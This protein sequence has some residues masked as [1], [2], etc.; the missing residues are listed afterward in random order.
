VLPKAIGL[1]P[2]KTSWVLRAVA[3]GLLRCAILAGFLVTLDTFAQPTPATI[4]DIG[5]QTIA[6]NSST[7]PIG[8]TI[9]DAESAAAALEL[10]A[11]SSNTALVPLS[12]IDF[13][14]I[15]NTRTVTVTPARTMTGEALIT[16][17]VTDGQLNASDSFLVRVT[18]PNTPPTISDIPDQK[19]DEDG[20]TEP[21]AFSIV[22][23]ETP[24][25]QLTLDVSSNNQQLV[26]SPGSASV[27]AQSARTVTVGRRQAI[28]LGADCHHRQRRKRLPR[29]IALRSQSVR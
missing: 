18:P 19:I 25:D 11:A 22:D 7:G 17:T 8:F 4:S 13:G 15:R 26:P 10:R 16:I 21:V 6:V 23:K 1:V 12:G 2:G 24:L 27:A 9:D 20:T 14:G 5:D 28:R 3:R 29:W